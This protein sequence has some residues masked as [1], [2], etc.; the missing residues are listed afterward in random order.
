VWTTSYGSN[1]T[2]HQ[3]DPTLIFPAGCTAD[4]PECSGFY[5]GSPRAFECGGD[6][7]GE[8]L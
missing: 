5:R 8:L 3:D 1:P 4:I 7:W 6:S 2:K